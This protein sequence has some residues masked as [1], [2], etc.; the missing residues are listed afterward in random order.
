VAVGIEIGHVIARVVIADL[1]GQLLHDPLRP[2]D[3]LRGDFDEGPGE[4]L[5]WATRRARILLAEAGADEED[6]VGVG[7]SLAGPVNARTGE[8]RASMGGEWVTIQPAL[9]LEER[10][11]WPCPFLVDNDAN[12]SAIAEHVHVGGG[13]ADMVYL[14]WAEGIGAGI[15]IDHRLHRG[16]GGVAGEIGHTL[17]G[18]EKTCERCEKVGCLETIA[19]LEAMLDRTDIDAGQDRAKALIAAA[20]GG[21]EKAIEAIRD[22]AAAIGRA[23]GP[24][25]NTLNPESLVLGGAVGAQAYPIVADQL[26]VGLRDVTVEPALRDVNIRSG[27]LF[28][29]TTVRG[30]VASVLR[31]HLPAYIRRKSE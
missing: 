20:R 24:V 13:V 12:C 16:A 25:L 14:K 2:E 11:E 26:R 19:S 29:T 23:I 27:R 10:L 22:A 15:V 6:V 30:A 31:E 5:D 1:H 3:Q 28:G 21:D 9:D 7:I 17:V 18:G 4:V 8:I